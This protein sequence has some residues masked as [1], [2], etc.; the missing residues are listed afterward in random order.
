M[1]IDAETAAGL[2][3]RGIGRMVHNCQR[4]F[5][6]TLERRLRRHA[7]TPSHWYHLNELWTE[8]GLTQIE[9]SKRLEIEKASSTQVL[10][11]LVQRG[12]IDRH[13]VSDDRRK[14]ANHL[15]PRG[16]TLVAQ[17]LEEMDRLSSQSQRGVTERDM[18]TFL[19]VLMR[20]TTNLR[21]MSDE[22]GAG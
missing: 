11:D 1:E 15:T 18:Q 21:A 16:R 7:I 3:R 19:K 13:R 5:Q 10:D 17:L 9:M 12:L 4:A 6:S 2:P 22:L 20:L 8:D 14:I